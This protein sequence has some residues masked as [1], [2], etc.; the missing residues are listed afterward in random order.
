MEARKIGTASDGSDVLFSVAALEADGILPINRVKPHT[1]FPGT[2]GSGIL[3]ML[4]IGFGKQAGA[5]STH[6]AITHR[7]YEVVLREFS[8]IIL[9]AVPVLGSVAIVEDQRHQ[10]AAVEVLAPNNIVS[11]EMRLLEKARPDAAPASR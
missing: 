5:N 10:T 4:T 7:G 1:D 2:L 9:D 3:K 6:R 11:G 8:G